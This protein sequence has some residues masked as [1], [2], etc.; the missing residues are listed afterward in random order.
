LSI[1]ID[2]VTVGNHA[3]LRKIE[4]CVPAL[5]GIEGPGYLIDVLS[6]DAFALRQFEFVA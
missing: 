3:K 6:Q 2:S 5:Q 4:I 1:E